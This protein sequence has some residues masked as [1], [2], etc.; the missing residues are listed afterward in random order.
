MQQQV[1]IPF[2]LRDNATGCEAD[3]TITI[4]QPALP[5]TMSITNLTDFNCNN[6]NAQIT[7]S[8]SGGTTDYG[9]AAVPATPLTVPTTFANSNV[10]TVDTNNGT[11]VDWIVF[12][13]D[14]NGCTTSRS[15]TINRAPT[16]TVTAA[17]TG[18]CD[19]TTGSFTITATGSNGIGALTY[20]IN[21]ETGAFQSDPVFTVIPRATPYTVWVKDANG[22]T[23][24]ATPIT[25]YPQLTVNGSVTKTLDCLT[26]GPN[27]TISATITGGRANYNYVI[28]NSVGTPVA[29]DSGVTG[30]TITYTGAAADTYTVTVTDTNTP[31][32]NASTTIKVDPITPPTVAVATQVNVSCTGGNDGS[33]TLIGSGG[34]GGYHLQ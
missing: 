19:S 34:S 7:V 24:S 3:G 23:S 13:R 29:S 9:Y 8:A 6:D 21:G 20:G 2:V 16:P 10:V 4:N 12:V 11:I 14:V 33:V 30:P 15:V 22:C 31:S 26:A 28:T 17:L 1:P 5:L 25:V 18:Q 27:A 32:C